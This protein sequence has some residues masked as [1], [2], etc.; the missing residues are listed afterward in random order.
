MKHNSLNVKSGCLSEGPEKSMRER[1]ES[2]KA[3]IERGEVGGRGT[4]LESEW[5]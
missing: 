1:L 4:E 3:W 5:E 2:M